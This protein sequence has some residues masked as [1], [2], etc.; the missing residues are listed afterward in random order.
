ME[1]KLSNGYVLT[2]GEIEIRSA[3]WERD[4]WEGPLIP[5]AIG[6]PRLQDAEDSVVVS[7]RLPRSCAEAVEIASADR[8]LSKSEFYRQ[9]VDHELE[10]IAS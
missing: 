6:R 5:I 9:A 1:H 10:A 8:G 2:D 7:F 3:E 4:Q